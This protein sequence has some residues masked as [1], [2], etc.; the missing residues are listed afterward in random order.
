M[1]KVYLS[2]RTD[3]GFAGIIYNSV[4]HIKIAEGAAFYT[5]ID[6]DKMCLQLVYENGETATYYMDEIVTMLVY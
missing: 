5:D 3:D 4:D 2:I 1:K 6:A